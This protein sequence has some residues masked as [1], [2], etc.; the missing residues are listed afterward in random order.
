MPDHLIIT[1]K[2]RGKRMGKKR[3]GDNRGTDEEV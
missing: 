1:R 3:Q 2:K